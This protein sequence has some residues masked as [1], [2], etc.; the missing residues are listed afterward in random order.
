MVHVTDSYS[1]L[2]GRTDPLSSVI[3]DV[4]V[5][6]TTHNQTPPVDV[7]LRGCLCNFD[8][9]A[10]IRNG[11]LSLFVVVLG[12]LCLVRVTKLIDIGRRYHQVTV[13]TLASIECLLITIHWLFAHHP[14][15]ELS[16]QLMKMFQLIVVCHFYLARSVRMLKKEYLNRFIV[17]PVLVLFCA[18]FLAITIVGAVTSII[19]D[20]QLESCKDPFWV[21]FSAAECALVQ[22]F[23]ICGIYITKKLNNVT[24]LR[25]Q[26]RAQKRNLWSIILAFELS[27]IATLIYDSFMLGSMDGHT[28]CSDVYND[29][30]V[31]YSVVY[32]LLMFFKIIVPI[33][34]LLVVFHPVDRVDQEE[35]LIS[36]GSDY[37]GYYHHHRRLY[38]PGTSGHGF[39]PPPPPVRS[40]ARRTQSF[41]RLPMITEEAEPT[42]I[43]AS[44][45]TSA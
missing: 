41:P 15:L 3:E 7:V 8:P 1:F 5:A 9:L 27:S 43:N 35:R 44:L 6:V 19:H 13:F 34:T 17:L 31:S 45:P 12:L 32:L 2:A 40:P 26:K 20:R 21:M 24:M 11:I 38:S 30:N 25:S 36:S 39:T 28:R 22:M 42:S 4:L 14:A 10:C 33:L 23:L 16:V 37:D 29:N 18:Y